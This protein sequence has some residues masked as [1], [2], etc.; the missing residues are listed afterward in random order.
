MGVRVDDSADPK[1]SPDGPGSILRINCLLRFA[2]MRQKGLSMYRKLI[3][4]SLCLAVA[5]PA[6]AQNKADKRLA[7][8]TAVLKTIMGKNDIPKGVLDKA[9]CVMVFPSVR[10]V[11]VGLGVTYG[12]GVLVCR[13]GNDFNGKWGAPIMYSLDTGSLG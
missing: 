9:V 8:S 10:K 3:I 7:E 11:G 12:R 1:F 6:F 4:A 13:T 2:S 5:L